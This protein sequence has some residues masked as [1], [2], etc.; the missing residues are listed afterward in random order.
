[1]A[2]VNASLEVV[3]VVP[4]NFSLQS[5]SEQPRVLHGEPWQT[6]LPEHRLLLRPVDRLV[7]LDHVL[8]DAHVVVDLSAV[9]ASEPLRVGLVIARGR[10]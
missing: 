4:V 6:S 10:K 2:L 9:R 1:M 3:E 5:L 8:A 7:D